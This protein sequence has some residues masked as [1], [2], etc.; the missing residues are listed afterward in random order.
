VAFGAEWR[1]YVG[2]A[3]FRVDAAAAPIAGANL[4]LE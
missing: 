2:L 3:D 4:E 1:L